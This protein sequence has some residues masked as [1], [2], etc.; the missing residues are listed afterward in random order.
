MTASTA[1]QHRL[2][3]LVRT[4][5][6][7][8]G[9]GRRYSNLVRSLR[10][11]LPLLA[12]GLLL[13]AII[14]PQFD[15]GQSLD[16]SELQVSLKDINSQEIRMRAARL[17]GTD[18]EGRPFT[19]TA[20]EARQLAGLTG[21]VFLDQPTGRIEMADGVVV[22]FRADN[23]EY[24]RTEEHAV[25]RGNVVVTHGLGYEFQTETAHVDLREARAYGDVPVSGFGPEGTLHGSGFEILDRGET[26]RMLGR[27][28]MVITDVPKQL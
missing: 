5:G 26:V 12:G 27:S 6:R 9:G 10:L 16:T 23:G 19:V 11:V 8:G 3:R 28:R 7:Q 15:L 22:T 20:V 24:D 4:P 21:T 18:K 13:L 25:F 17:V 14:W 1:D 2:G